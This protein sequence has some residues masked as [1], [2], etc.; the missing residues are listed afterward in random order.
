MKHVYEKPL[1]ASKEEG[2]VLVALAKEKGLSIGGPDT[3]LG[4]S[5][6][7]C[8]KLIDDGFIGNHWL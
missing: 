4:A 6:Q 2:E 3:F 1:G 5:L 7:T 8:R